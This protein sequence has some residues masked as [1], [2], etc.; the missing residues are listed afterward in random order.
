MWYV[1]LCDAFSFSSLYNLR[2][3]YLS[4]K[5]ITFCSHAHTYT[6][7]CV[8]FFLI[9]YFWTWLFWL[10]RSDF[11][12]YKGEINLLN[13][14]DWWWPDEINQN[15]VLFLFVMKIPPSTKRH[16]SIYMNLS[17]LHKCIKWRER[18]K[19]QQKMKQN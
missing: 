13:W 18:E 19:K 17:A 11:F 5:L 7:E 2:R 10:C 12:I 9:Y 8:K 15:H 1:W 16:C 4:C 3:A 14:S 6:C